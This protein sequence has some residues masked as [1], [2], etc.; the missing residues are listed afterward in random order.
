VSTLAVGGAVL[1]G[2]FGGLHC[3]AMCGPIAAVLCTDA[4]RRGV[5]LRVGAA[6]NAGR[7]VTYAVLGAGLG[8]LGGQLSASLELAN[9]QLTA[10][11]VAAAALI[12]AGA[13]LSGVLR[14]RA[15]ARGSTAPVS[16]SWGELLRRSPGVLPAFARGLVW[17]LLPCGLVY[18]ALALA[19]AAGSAPLGALCMLAFGVATLPAIGVATFLAG[20]ATPWLRHAAIRATA[21]LLLIVSGSVHAAMAVVAS[22]ALPV[23]EE[24]RPCCASK[25]R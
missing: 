6:T 13:R 21:G 15:R 23:P 25:Q 20:R 22:G 24:S 9:A 19:L 17:G 7:L 1:M 10:R 14:A 16:R 12:V 2:L 4:D 8:A 18:A 3:V 5:D 11:L